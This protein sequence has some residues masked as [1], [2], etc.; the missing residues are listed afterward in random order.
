MSV[1]Y[2]GVAGAL[3]GGPQAF[4]SLI[5]FLGTARVRTI[6]GEMGDI[7]QKMMRFGWLRTWW[8]GRGGVVAC[9]GPR[10]VQG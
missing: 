1:S 4:L 8:V 9:R 7:T 5:V 10:R 3:M 6:S 2:F